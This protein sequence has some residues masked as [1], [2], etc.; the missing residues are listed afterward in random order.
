ML[1]PCKN[2]IFVIT[3]TN[4][5]I[6][7]NRLIVFFLIYFMSYGT[8]FTQSTLSA[9]Y[10]LNLLNLSNKNVSEGRIRAH[11]FG[12][13]IDH[14]TNRNFIIGIGIDHRSSNWNNRI[15]DEDSY[16]GK[17][18]QSVV[19]KLYNVKSIGIN[20]D[21]GFAIKLK[22]SSTVLIKFRHHSSFLYDWNIYMYD[23]TKYTYEGDCSNTE[24]SELISV[25]SEKY[26][27]SELEDLR[28][29][30]RVPLIP[31]IM[32]GFRKQW[33]N[34]WATNL[35]LGYGLGMQQ[36]IR[37]HRFIFGLDVVYFLNSKE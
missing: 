28:V 8:T 35:H 1:M 9:G 26:E 6:M 3:T 19:T 32:L 25:T 21:I 37:K 2:H 29:G 34:K 27:D 33:T 20:F 12:I 5:I 15:E 17:C 31:D 16:N 14:I 4:C 24:N 23:L 30:M 36:P 13:G 7:I 18:F 22:D 10:E 11:S